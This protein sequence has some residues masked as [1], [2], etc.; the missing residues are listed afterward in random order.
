M[1]IAEFRR[2]INVKRC[3]ITIEAYRVTILHFRIDRCRINKQYPLVAPK[4]AT[5]P[6]VWTASGENKLRPVAG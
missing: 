5:V 4:S 2:C 6:V 3:T 1:R